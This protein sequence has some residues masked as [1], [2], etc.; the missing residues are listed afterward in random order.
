MDLDSGTLYLSTQIDKLQMKTFKDGGLKDAR[1]INIRVA[2]LTNSFRSH[3]PQ[4]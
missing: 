2:G 1:A 3:R 4:A